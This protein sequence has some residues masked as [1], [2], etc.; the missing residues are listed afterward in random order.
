MSSLLGIVICGEAQNDLEEEGFNATT[1][2]KAEL[3]AS[4]TTIVAYNKTRIAAD[5]IQKEVERLESKCKE[6]GSPCLVTTLKSLGVFQIEY[7]TS[8]HPS[9]D[10]LDLNGNLEVGVEDSVIHSVSTIPPND[11]KYAEQW[12]YNSR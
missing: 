12:Y 1:L 7:E 5:D 2:S 11:S 3:K 8:D 4:K 6:L 10:E 9:L